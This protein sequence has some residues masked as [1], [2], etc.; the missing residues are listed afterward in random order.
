MLH[1]PETTFSFQEALDNESKANTGLEGDKVSVCHKTGY[2]TF[3]TGT[4]R[5]Y[6]YIYIC[7][8]IKTGASEMIPLYPVELQTPPVNQYINKN[9]IL[10]L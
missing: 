5:K 10:S 1:L 6:I 4:G 8:K 3:R 9:V 2:C 7:F